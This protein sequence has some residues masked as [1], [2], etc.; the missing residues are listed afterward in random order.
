MSTAV[1]PHHAAVKAVLEAIPNLTVYDGEVDPSPPMGQDKR[2][3]PYAVLWMGSGLPYAVNFCR[4]FSHLDLRW[5]VTVA[6]GDQQR[7]MLARDWVCAAFV[8]TRLTVEGRASGLVR[9]IE[10]RQVD[11]D[12]DVRPFRFFVPL[13][14]GARTNPS[15]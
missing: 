5:Q 12:R 7:V 11:V 4:D 9:L 2:A 15:A 13:P 6:G 8:G 1:L 3:L 14:F 10:Q